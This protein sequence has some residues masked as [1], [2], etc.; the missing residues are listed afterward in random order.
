MVVGVGNNL[1][2]SCVFVE[3]LLCGC[4]CYMLG[5]AHMK[6]GPAAGGE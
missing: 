1:K 3:Y 6:C 4:I 2:I 5:L